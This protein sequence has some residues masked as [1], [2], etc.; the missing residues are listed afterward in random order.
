MAYELYIWDVR[1]KRNFSNIVQNPLPTLSRVW[2]YYYMYLFFEMHRLRDTRLFSMTNR[3][4]TI[5]HFNVAIDSFDITVFT[6]T[7]FCN[8]HR[9]VFTWYLFIFNSILFNTWIFRGGKSFPKP[10]SH[11]HYATGHIYDVIRMDCA[12]CNPRAL[13]NKPRSR[14]VANFKVNVSIRKATT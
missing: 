1:R 3:N 14:T 11:L 9:N 13:E 8:E 4:N 5:S 6:H 12:P 2:K 10:P 7:R